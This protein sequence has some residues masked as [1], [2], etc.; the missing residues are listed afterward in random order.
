MYNG[1][2][3]EVSG[4]IIEMVRAGFE[5]A[6]RGARVRNCLKTSNTAAEMQGKHL[7]VVFDAINENQNARQLLQKIDQMVGKEKYD[8]LKVVIVS[9]A[10]SLENNEDAGSRWQKGATIVGE[11]LKDSKSSYRSLRSRLEPFGKGNWNRPTKI[12]SRCMAC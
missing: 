2:R 12:T 1:A 3:L 5:E 4:T 8:W 9:E 10:R 11:R 6:G 7:I